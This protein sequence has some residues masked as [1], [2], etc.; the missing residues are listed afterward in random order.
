[1]ADDGVVVWPCPLRRSAI[2]HEGFAALSAAEEAEE[3]LTVP[4]VVRDPAAVAVLSVAGACLAC[5]ALDP[6]EAMAGIT[7]A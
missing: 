6:C 7:S 3:L 1:M 5:E 4:V 2:P